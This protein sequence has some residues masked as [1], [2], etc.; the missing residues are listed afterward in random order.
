MSALVRNFG[1]FWTQKIACESTNIDKFDLIVSHAIGK[2]L[3]IGCTDYPL[4]R[5]GELHSRLL[6]KN[7]DVDGYDIDKVGIS[8]LKEMLPNKK[9]YSNIEEIDSSYDLII[10]PEVIEHVTSHEKFFNQIDNIQFNKF[11]LSVPNLMKNTL[12]FHYDAD[13]K[14]FYE[15]IHPDHKFWFS[16]YTICNLIEACSSWKIEQVYLMHNNSQ[17][18][19]I[20]SK[21]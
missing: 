9:F 12:E 18:V 2:V 13:N 16:P 10:I 6:E 21:R 14:E 4:D 7:I 5:V 20:G 19:V 8:K 3:H 15:A 17:V 1:S 11:L